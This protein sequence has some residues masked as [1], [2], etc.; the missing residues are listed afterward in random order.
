MKPGLLADT[1]TAGESPEMRGLAA[2]DLDGDGLIE[3]VATTT[4]TQDTA[5]VGAQVFVFA[6]N[7]TLFQPAGLSYAAWPRYNN[8]C[9]AGGDADR[10]GMG[11]S[12]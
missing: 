10:N 3:V 4:Q 5:D 11:H 1:T 7:G 2:A 12:G 9:G 6:Y 8:R